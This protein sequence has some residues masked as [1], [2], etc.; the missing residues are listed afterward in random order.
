MK[1]VNYCI[2]AILVMVLAGFSLT[3]CMKN[4]KEEGIPLPSEEIKGTATSGALPNE[5][6]DPINRL[7]DAVNRLEK[8]L[9]K[10]D[11]QPPKPSN[12]DQF[13]EI[14]AAGTFSTEKPKKPIKK[15]V[16]RTYSRHETCQI[17][18]RLANL[19]EIVYHNHPGNKIISVLYRPGSGLL[20]SREKINIKK[21]YEESWLTGKC[22]FE[23]IYSYASKA[24]PKPPVKN[25]DISQLRLQELITFL[26]ELGFP[27]PRLEKLVIQ[28]RGPTDRW[29]NNL[30][31]TIKVQWNTDQEEIDKLSKERTQ[32]APPSK[33]QP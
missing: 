14:P 22:N 26:K 31:V 1:K 19:E 2:I 9:A 18:D 7:T 30:R 23:G 25:T 5:L 15:K 3:G 8:R 16:V 28:N 27:D 6:A 20:S 11:G 29:N 17:K 24:K 10:P 32:Y 21:L 13:G 33:N 4:I 12:E